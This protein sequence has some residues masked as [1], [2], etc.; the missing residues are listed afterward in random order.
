MTSFRQRR[1]FVQWVPA[2]AAS[3]V[4]TACGGG[5]SSDPEPPPAPVTP[6]PA[7]A[8][9]PASLNA[10][11]GG[12]ATFS[13]SLKDSAGA[14]YQWL[15]NG[16]PIE[17][18]TQSSYALPAVAYSDH[19]SRFSVRAS[20]AGGA[21]TSA[22]AALSISVPAGISIFVPYTRGE[23]LDLLTDAQGY[24][25]AVMTIT[26]ANRASGMIV[27]KYAPATGELVPF[28]AD[29]LGLV[30]PGASLR[31]SLQGTSYG[32]AALAPSGDF[33]VAFAGTSA[34][35]FNQFKFDS[36]AIYRVSASGE[37]TTLI[38]WPRESAG[39]IAP[40]GITRGADGT[41]YFLDYLSRRLMSWTPLLGLMTG[42][43]VPIASS[44]YGSR[45]VRLAVDSANRVYVLDEKTLW[46][47]VQGQAVV[48]HTTE[49]NFQG[50]GALT[51]D[52]SGNVYVAE[53]TIIQK[54]ALNDA[55][56]PVAG[57]V[58]STGLTT[59]ALPGNLGRELGSIAID[60][61]GD[62]QVVTVPDGT[63]VRPTTILKIRLP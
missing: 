18:A 10:P 54:V 9:Q 40:M 43:V 8:Q 57:Q 41:L 55:V 36:G 26:Y 60:V 34:A 61:N 38:S 32:G 52:P 30:V 19:G 25:Y 22:E 13:V 27:R 2:V 21:I 28:G 14:S 6:P 53:N 50:M 46:R 49:R 62:I 7:I 12:S 58:R 63:Q 59:G 17:G 31:E 39:A 16:T 44:I 45:L 3:L 35:G 56:T 24:T 1:E 5:G 11:A 48:I 4:V 47:V 33:Y 15:R 29:G 42:P 23:V 20:N 51:L 37:T